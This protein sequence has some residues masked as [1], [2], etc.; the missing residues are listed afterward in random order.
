MRGPRRVQ[1]A[2]CTG[3]RQGVDTDTVG[4]NAALLVLVLIYTEQSK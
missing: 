3:I 2:P 4:G 1:G